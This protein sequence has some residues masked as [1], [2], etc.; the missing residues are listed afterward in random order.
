MKV[1]DQGY[2]IRLAI[3]GFTKVYPQDPYRVI[4]FSL[5]NLIAIG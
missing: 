2:A 4:P 3:D 5:V 1:S